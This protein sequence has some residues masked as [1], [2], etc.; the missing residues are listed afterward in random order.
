MCFASISEVLIEYVSDGKRVGQLLLN[1]EDGI[2]VLPGAC[3]PAS[4]RIE[5]TEA[6]SLSSESGED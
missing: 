1:I 3:G 2:G 6:R 5:G 4:P